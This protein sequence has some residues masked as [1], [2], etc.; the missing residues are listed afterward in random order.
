MDF[1]AIATHYFDPSTELHTTLVLELARVYQEGLVTG[2][3]QR[4]IINPDVTQLVITNLGQRNAQLHDDKHQL[5]MTRC[6]YCGEYPK[7]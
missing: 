2:H 3:E 4:E 7:V 5:R 1:E 6:H